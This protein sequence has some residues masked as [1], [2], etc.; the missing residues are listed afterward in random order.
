M[1][2][3]LLPAGRR[4]IGRHASR[5]SP[6]KSKAG[7]LSIP[8]GG[9]SLPTWRTAPTVRSR[10]RRQRLTATPCSA[11]VTAK[12]APEVRPPGDDAVL[13]VTAAQHGVA[14]SRW[15]RESERT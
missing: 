11:A 3:P 7:R 10:S 5:D 1:T 13:A 9:Q 4:S 12:T 14:V 8:A 6:A 15:L 2:D